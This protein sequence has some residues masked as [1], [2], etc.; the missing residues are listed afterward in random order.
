MS[1]ISGLPVMTTPADDDELPINDVSGPT[2]KKMLLSKLKEYLQSL[3]AWIS[4]GM[5]TNSYKFSA[6]RN[7]AWTQSSAAKKITFDTED[8]DTN[9]DFD[10]TNGRYTAPVNGYYQVNGQVATPTVSGIG[11]NC[12]LYKN[13]SAYRTGNSLVASHTGG[14]NTIVN[15]SDLVYLTAGDYIEVYHVGNNSPAGTTGRAT[16]FSGHLVTQT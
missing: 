3:L 9:S 12:T 7:G 5:W 6:Y 14:F 16:S 11:Y 2:T 13:G 8:F 15:F 1:K 10:T 4:P